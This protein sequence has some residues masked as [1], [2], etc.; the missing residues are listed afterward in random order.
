MC[1][2]DYLLS[3]YVKGKTPSGP[4]RASKQIP[5]RWLAENV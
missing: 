5:K 3:S 1:V 4:L 2:P